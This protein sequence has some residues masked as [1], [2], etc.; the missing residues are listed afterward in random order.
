MKKTVVCGI[1]VALALILSYIESLIPIPVP[2]PGIKLGLAN[3]AV[4]FAL[5]KMN[6]S[7]AAFISVIRVILVGF[8]FGSLSATIYGLAGAVLALVTM[9]I[10]KRC[11]GLHIITISICG[12]L[13]H[14]AGQMSVAGAVT[15]YGAVMYY[16]PYLLAVSLVTGALIGYLANILINRIPVW[17]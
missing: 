3:I 11:T 7:Y 8:M 9:T 6:W 15:D 17:D 5:Y 12:A 16:A 14:I 10:L 1:F 4:V 13:A 2:I